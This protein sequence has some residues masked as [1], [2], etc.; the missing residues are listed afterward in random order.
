MATVTLKITDET[1]GGKRLSD[2]EVTV[3]N[4]LTT[5]REII[6]ARVEAE[7]KAYNTKRPEYFHGLVQPTEAEST[8]NGYRMKTKKEVDAEKQYLTAFDAFQKNRY[9]IL[10]DNIQAESLDQMVVV[11][12]DTN[13]SFVKLTPLIG[14]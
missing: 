5:V 8:L 7:V 4:E 11:N 2:M 1:A 14:G 3:G 6:K 13:I 12:A 10:I 9:F